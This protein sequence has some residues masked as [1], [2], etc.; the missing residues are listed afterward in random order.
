LDF[1]ALDRNGNILLVEF[2]HGSSTSGIYLSPLQIGMY[3][4]IFTS[5][6]RETLDNAIYEMIAQKQAIGL[7]NPNWKL[8]SK[9]KNIIPVLV[10]SN[11]NSSNRNKANDRFK[12]ILQFVKKK[13]GEDFLN[14]LQIYNFCENK[15]SYLSF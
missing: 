3:Y 15:L 1:L 2:K 12:E 8:P 10:I 11:F 7:L 4:D 13:K 6:P 5:L 14:N 9:L